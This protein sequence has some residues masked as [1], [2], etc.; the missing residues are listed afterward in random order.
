ML[1]TI[2]AALPVLLAQI[3]LPGGLGSIGGILILVGWI[4]LIVMGFK[5]HVVW[6]LVVLLIPALGGIVYGAVHWP[7]TMTPLI[8]LI[9]GL[10][11]GG[12]PLGMTLF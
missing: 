1:P 12:A 4:W 5:T 6:G 2:P 8:I 9:I 7:G 3:H 11:I 10:V